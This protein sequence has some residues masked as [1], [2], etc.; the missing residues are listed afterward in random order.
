MTFTK[1]GLHTFFIGPN[2]QLYTN[3][4]V[5]L[6]TNK[7]NPTIELMLITAVESFIAI[8]SDVKL[9]TQFR[10]FEAELLQSCIL[11]TAS[12]TT[13][14]KA[15]LR[16]TCVERFAGILSGQDWSICQCYYLI[17]YFHPS[18]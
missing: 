5:T 1:I 14:N 8:N 6:C 9:N 2:I 4:Y 10:P 12:V 16:Q 7:V 3:S 17:D 15:S 11:S 18:Q 13:P